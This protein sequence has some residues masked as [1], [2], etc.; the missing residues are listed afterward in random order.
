MVVKSILKRIFNLPSK[1]YNMVV[2]AYRKPQYS[3]RP[4]INGKIY[5]ISDKGSIYFG[6]KRKNKIL[7]LPRDPIGGCTRTI[8]FAEPGAC[9]KIGNNVGISNTAIHASESVIIEDDVLIGGVAKFMI[10]I[11]IV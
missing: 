9:I 3:K 5:L 4:T 10:Q 2:F 7:A 1:I 11:F 8:L 6:E